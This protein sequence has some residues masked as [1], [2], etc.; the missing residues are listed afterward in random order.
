M[1]DFLRGLLT[2]AGSSI[3]GG[4]AGKLE[5]LKEKARM[6]RENNIARL[7]SQY[8]T[9]EIKL[10][11]KLAGEREASRRVWESGE[12]EAEFER[13]I[14]QR[15]T[16]AGIADVQEE[17]KYD[18]REGD[19]DR[20]FEEELKRA[21]VLQIDMF[22]LKEEKKSDR[23]KLLAD[24]VEF[25][26]EKEGT[27]LFKE[28]LTAKTDI[29]RRELFAKMYAAR[30]KMFEDDYAMTEAEKHDKALKFAAMASGFVPAGGDPYEERKKK[31]LGGGTA[32]ETGVKTAAPAPKSGKQ[33][34]L[35]EERPKEKTGIEKATELTPSQMKRLVTHRNVKKIGTYQGWTIGKETTTGGGI[36]IQVGGKWYYPDDQ[37]YRAFVKPFLDKNPKSV[38]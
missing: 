34:G 24:Y 6:E 7:N 4:A 11:D 8:R 14:L 21:R 30:A 18:R 12:K 28:S 15:E 3:A 5:E 10:T 35:L 9:S 16:E 1:A 20:R 17:T 33:D 2:V 25:F 29:K 19:K 31:A 23:A 26:G 38:D 36:I 22:N 27:A 37:Q 32:G 13:G